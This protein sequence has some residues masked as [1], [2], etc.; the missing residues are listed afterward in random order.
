MSD[1]TLAHTSAPTDDQID[2]RINL[3]GV[4]G[5]FKIEKI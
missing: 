5:N 1:T 2:R 3:R 4:L